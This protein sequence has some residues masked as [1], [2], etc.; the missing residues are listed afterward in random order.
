MKYE[1]LEAGDAQTLTRLV[2]ER[3]TVGWA[4]LGPPSI[5]RTLA[6][7][8][9][10]GATTVYRYRYSQAITFPQSFAT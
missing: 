5:V 2:N 8:R 3:L 7:A 6:E 9:H 1:I 4:V 10:Q